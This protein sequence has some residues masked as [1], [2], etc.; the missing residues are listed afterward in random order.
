MFL[1]SQV[2][3][4]VENLNMGIL[5]DTINVINVRLCMMVLLIKCYM[6]IPLSATLTKFEG[7]SNVEQKIVTENFIFLGLLSKSS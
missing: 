5:T 4:L 2:Y 6:L 3:G 1:V 7:H